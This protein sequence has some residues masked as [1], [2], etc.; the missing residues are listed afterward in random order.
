MGKRSRSQKYVT[1]RNKELGIT[2]FS[3]QCTKV[4]QPILLEKVTL[5]PSPTPGHYYWNCTEC[6]GSFSWSRQINTMWGHPDDKAFC[7]VCCKYYEITNVD[8][9]FNK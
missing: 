2:P 5:N 6:K 4:K 1:Q 3:K 8:N 9:R 7:A